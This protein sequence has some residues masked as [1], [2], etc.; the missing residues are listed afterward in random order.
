MTSVP[1][2]RVQTRSSE[3]IMP[4]TAV[5]TRAS[6][7]PPRESLGQGDG[8]P[9]GDFLM[10]RKNWLFYLPAERSVGPNFRSE[11]SGS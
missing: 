2:S 10:S 11:I 7:P 6:P 3:P 5:T 8:V 1:A 9:L 4:Y